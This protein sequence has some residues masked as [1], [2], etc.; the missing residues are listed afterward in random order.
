MAARFGLRNR[1]IGGSEGIGIPVTTPAPSEHIREESLWFGT[2]NRP[3]FGR[4]TTPL[5]ETTVGAVLLSPPIGRE[6]RLARR[7][8]RTLAIYLATDGYVSLRYDHFGTGDS[9]GSMDDL[10][11]DQAWTEGVDQGVGLLRSLGIST[12]SAVGMRMGA[13]IVGKAA[14]TFDLNLASFAMWDPC[15]SGHTYV[16]ELVALGALGPEV[17]EA[18]SEPTKMLEYALS[19]DAETRMQHFSLV[20][21]PTSQMAERVLVIARDDRPVS[22]RFRSRWGS[23]DVEWITTS[24]QGALLEPQLPLSVQPAGT[25]AKLRTWLTAFPAPAVSLGIQTPSSEAVVSRE[26]NRYPVQERV[27]GLGTRQMF[28]IVSEPVGETDGPLI[29]M[30]NGVNEDHVGPARLWVE[31]SRRWAGLG[32]RCARFDLSELGES[33]WLPGQPDRPVFDTTRRQDIVDAVRSLDPENPSNAVLFGY[34]SG[35][36][37]ALEVATEL[38]T[39]GVCVINPEVGAGNVPNID[40]LKLS[41]RESTRS[42]VHRAEQYLNRHRRADKMIR[43]VLRFLLA[44]TYP[45][46]M[47][48]EL[49]A[50]KSDVLLLLSP[51]DLSPLREVP[52]LGALSRRRLASTKNL[53][54]RVVS[55]L[56]HS[57]LSTLGRRQVVAIL[58]Q[59]VVER[60]AHAASPLRGAGDADSG[61]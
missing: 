54:I 44:S 4:L 33:P 23:G 9:S 22:S 14:S 18:G 55:G 52:V 39:R 38:M 47:P 57:M 27:L 45:P 31:L 58:D 3:L 6:S 11:F 59:F 13:A 56:D 40:R 2:P 41:G 49:V 51:D 46:K 60:Y 21:S 20:E 1:V 29:V 25:I 37:L 61:S 34:C 7:A 28:G 30:V 12:V 50:A 15:E 19:D 42:I 16:R 43:G 8:L 48:R 10:E 32:L 17:L 36:Q 26:E 24:E 5:G 53:R 35:A